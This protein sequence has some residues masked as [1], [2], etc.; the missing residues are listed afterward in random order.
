MNY[1]KK[2]IANELNWKGTNELTTANVIKIC[3]FDILRI[4]IHILYHCNDV[5]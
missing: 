3:K 5:S 4:E 1:E 2:C